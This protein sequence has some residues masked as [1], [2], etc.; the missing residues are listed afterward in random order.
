M[1]ILPASLRLRMIISHTAVVSIAVAAA[2][3]ALIALQASPAPALAATAL[4]GSLGSIA[5]SLLIA[6]P[7][8]RPI[9]N[10]AEGARQLA[11]GNLDHRVKTSHLNETRQLDEAF[12]QMALTLQDLIRDLD[13]QHSLLAIVIETM[14]D[15]VI[16][17]DPDNTIS[18]IN[19]AALWLLNAD[20]HTTRGRPLAETVRDHELLQLASSASSNRIQRAEIELLHHRRFLHATAL[21]ISGTPR[22]RVILTLQDV[23]KLRQVQNTR[24]E[25]VSNV[26]HELRSPLASVKAMVETLNAGAIHDTEAAPDFLSRI[27]HDIRR[28]ASMVDELLELSILDSGQM[29]IHL[30]PVALPEIADKI[31]ERFKPHAHSKNIKLLNHTQNNLPRLMA[32]PGKL[33][34]I[35]TNL[36]ENALKSTPQGGRVTLS[37]AAD[38]NHIAI[39]VADTGIGIPREHLPHIFER[40]YKVDRSRSNLGAGLG[41]AITRRLAEAHGGNITVRSV[42]GEG[43]TFTLTLNRAS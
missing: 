27:D 13:N 19:P 25:F 5:A 37:A 23:T 14:T 38:H 3:I 15:G 36:I 20:I 4:V 6:R 26:S 1:R 9:H 18:L 41:L 34:Q 21:P 10:V 31:I 2:G 7:I 40:F 17:L 24:R 35:L 11:G 42:E 8:A 32:D 39:Q 28:M 30:A 29:P 16:I 43:A 22:G 33:D 12:N